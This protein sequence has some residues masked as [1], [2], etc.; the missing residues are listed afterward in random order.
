[1][2]KN[3]S[4]NSKLIITN[5]VFLFI[6]S[7]FD[8]TPHQHHAIQIILSIGDKFRVQLENKI[9]HSKA[10]IIDSNI[11]HRLTGKND[12]QISLLIEPE[13]LYGKAITSNILYKKNVLIFDYTLPNIFY[14]QL[15][16]YVL[17]KH[18]HIEDI[19]DLIFNY[20]N[21]SISSLKEIDERVKTV[22]RIIKKSDQKQFTICNLAN[23]VYLSES[24]LQHL[25]K[26]Q[27]GISIK[28]YLLWS[29]MV[30]AIRIIANNNNFTFAAHKAGFAD[31]AHISRTCK[32][33]FGITLSDLFKSSSSIQVYIDDC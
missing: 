13:S 2:K 25:F 12:T 32:R 4:P 10:I 17:S 26:E 9:I 23:Y 27:I 28:R 1:M 20:L 16:N 6:G 11:E 7:V 30:D 22:V 33:M 15:K 3:L 19:I 8:T 29:K 24:R 18:T 31:S 14:A 21:I 5:G